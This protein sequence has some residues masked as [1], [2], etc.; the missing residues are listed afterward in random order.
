MEAI[1]NA[2]W[3][4]HGVATIATLYEQHLNS[5]MDNMC[6]G[7]H[8]Y[9]ELSIFNHGLFLDNFFYFVILHW[10]LFTKRQT[11]NGMTNHNNLNCQA[12]TAKLN[13]SF[14]SIYKVLLVSN[15]LTYMYLHVSI[16]HHWVSY[17]NYMYNTCEL[18][19]FRRS[20]IFGWPA[21]IR[22]IKRRKIF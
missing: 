18:G 1:S 2:T 20:N 5:H 3:H 14:W 16:T 9:M 15:W 22:N 8:W 17:R 10:M 21:G 4:C 6:N 7:R 19:N 11:W 13:F 12:R